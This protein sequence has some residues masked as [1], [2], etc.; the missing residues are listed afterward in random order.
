MDPAARF[1][2]IF[3]VAYP[4]LGRYALY[5]GVSKADAEDLVGATLEVAWR[6]L[7]EVPMDDPLPWLYAVERNLLMNLRRSNHRHTTLLAKLPTAEAT[8]ATDL[9]PMDPD[10][11]RL[12]SAL[13][14]LA[15]D[16][17][18][19]L[20]L[21]AWDELTPSQASIVLGISSVAART[22]L[23]RARRRLAT[24]FELEQYRRD[25]GQMPDS[26]SQPEQSIEVS[27]G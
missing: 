11:E 1:R 5:R 23:H 2:A 10:Q 21:V 8:P 19:I 9:E 15:V 18:E 20:R 27:D 14:A 3:D 4:A 7:N 16:D 12:R 25:V 26:S 17:R 22:R 24:Q 6:K 13:G